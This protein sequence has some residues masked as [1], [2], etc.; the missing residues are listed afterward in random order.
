[1]IL[2]LLIGL[3]TLFRE[4]KEVGQMCPCSNKETKMKEATCKI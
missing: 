3:L 1:M 4:N 2:E